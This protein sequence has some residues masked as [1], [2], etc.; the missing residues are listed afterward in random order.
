MMKNLVLVVVG[1]GLAVF[2]GLLIPKIGFTILTAICIWLGVMVLLSLQVASPR[3]SRLLS[4]AR[5]G[6]AFN[7]VAHLA[8]VGAT[9]FAFT[10]SGANEEFAFRLLV[11]VK[12]VAKPLGTGFDLLVNRYNWGIVLFPEYSN[13][14]LALT[15]YGNILAH[16]LMGVLLW[17]GLAALIGK[18]DPLLNRPV[19]P[20]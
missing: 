20:C 14:C 17:T 6:L 11:W 18:R 3:G 7:V 13:L 16:M 2:G 10:Q 5:I 1:I 15:F 9:H 19:E 8:L 12:W 4:A